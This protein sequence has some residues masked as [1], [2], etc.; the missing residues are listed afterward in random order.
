MPSNAVQEH[1]TT[2]VQEH[3]TTAVREHTTGSLAP[4][5]QSYTHK[6]RPEEVLLRTWERTGP[7][8]FTVTAQWPRDHRF[9]RT[10]HGLLDPM[11]L[12][13]TIRQTLP[14]LSH[15]AYAVPLGHQL[16]WQDLDW[17]LVAPD[18]EIPAGPE[19]P[20]ALHTG[21]HPA[22][23]LVEL[24][25]TCPKVTYRRDRAAA[26]ALTVQVLRDGA[27]FA[28]AHSRFTIQAR[29]VYE[30]L[31]GRYAD[32][33][34]VRVLPL[35]PPASPRPVG[36]DG[37][38]DVVL[39]PTH[40]PDRWQLRADTTHP[41]LFDHPV[42]HAPGMLLLEAARQAAQALAHPAP[43]VAVGMESVFTRYAELDSPCWILADAL[44]ADLVG[45]TRVRVT[46]RQNDRD[47]FTSTVTLAPA[48]AHP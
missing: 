23:A 24:R 19:G 27:P 41:I 48:P 32:I 3:V 34:A 46:A 13:E 39:S 5:P 10:R 35:S 7:D 42:D 6:T 9:Y 31:R 4:V 33:A 43:T 28:T 18:P 26:I 2:A 16:L 38:E 17:H 37:F 47:I 29:T 20:L 21:P 25:I 45:R 22:P 1:V 12:S 15:G 40:T 14:L 30:R 8:A 44:P 11:L 36:R